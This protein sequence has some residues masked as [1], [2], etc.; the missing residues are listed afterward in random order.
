M[1]KLSDLTGVN[2][3]IQDGAAAVPGPSPED[4]KR[5]QQQ[6]EYEQK[7]NYIRDQQMAQ[8][9]F[10]RGMLPNYQGRLNAFA[11]EKMRNL[12]NSDVT[13]IKEQ[14]N[15]RG[16]LYSGARQGAQL[17]AAAKR[18]SELAVDKNKV[19]DYLEK[20]AQE[21]DDAASKN[22]M[23]DYRDRIDQADQAYDLALQRIKQRN[24]MM[25]SIMT[26]GGTIAGGLLAR[27]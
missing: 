16:M 26:A 12:Y 7:R 17:N 5:Y 21:F 10:F 18:S 1:S 8:A 19:G 13:D 3:T 24:Q 9:K 23:D 4:T 22:I 25:G 11:E 14:M 15:K 20:Q 27:G 2:W 6:Q